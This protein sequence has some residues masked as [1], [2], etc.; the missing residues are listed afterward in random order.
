MVKLV[1]EYTVRPMDGMG[2]YIHIFKIIVGFDTSPLAKHA[3]LYTLRDYIFVSRRKKF[4][5][6][7]NWLIEYILTLV[8]FK[9]KH[10]LS[11]LNVGFREDKLCDKDNYYITRNINSE[12]THTRRFNPWP[13]DPHRWRSRELTIP[14]GSQTR[15]I[16]RYMNFPCVPGS[17]LPLF[18]Y[19]VIGDGH[20][21]N[22]RGLYTQYKDSY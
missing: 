21:P 4:K 22:S 3:N 11:G 20:Q 12:Y 19:T 1:G 5:L 10:Y 17:K 7:V 18:S 13:F 9:E 15:R 6:L 16:A 2:T 14:K 8:F